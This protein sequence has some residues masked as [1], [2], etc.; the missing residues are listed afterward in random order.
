MQIPD[1]NKAFASHATFSNWLGTLTLEQRQIG[2]LFLPSGLVVAGDALVEPSTEPF[3]TQLAP[4]RYP[5]V[6]SIARIEK[7]KDERIACAML[8][9]TNHIPVRWVIA[10]IGDQTITRLLE[11]QIFGY[12]V[13][14]GT[15]SFMSLE[16]AHVLNEKMKGD[17]SY[18]NYIIERMQ[19]NYIY[20]RDWADIE[21]DK[22]SGLNF[23]IFSSG[24]GDGFYA[25]YWGYDEM[26]QPACLVT[27]FG[28]LDED[29]EG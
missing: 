27:D 14:S 28:L 11:G 18:F 8:R 19:E 25:S 6:V 21:L 2:E 7:D 4:D 5:V 29:N 1:F 3:L 9:V 13:D 22:D 17:E 12:P 20:T 16:A 26:D 23:V 24:L 10:T 15:G